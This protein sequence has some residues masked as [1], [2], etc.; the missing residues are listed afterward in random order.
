MPSR[1][2]ISAIAA[3]SFIVPFPHILGTLAAPSAMA[4]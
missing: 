1:F 4:A 3:P 2:M